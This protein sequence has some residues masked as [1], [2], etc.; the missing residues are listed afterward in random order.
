MKILRTFFSERFEYL[1]ILMKSSFFLLLCLLSISING[2]N[3]LWQPS[4]IQNRAVQ[5][6][7]NPLEKG[8]RLL[9]TQ[10][11]LPHQP[12]R[13]FSACNCGRCLS[14]L[15]ASP[16]HT[17]RQNTSI[18]CLFGFNDEK[19]IYISFFVHL[20]MSTTRTTQ[21]YCKYFHF[22]WLYSNTR[23][24]NMSEKWRYFNENGEFFQWNWFGW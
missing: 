10:S 4:P 1:T 23:Y 7:N 9:D 16:N 8:D 17:H 14:H 24:D 12:W 21:T 22:K 19:N 3:H 6:Y 18:T 13:R 20:N 15:I 5:K 11:S 2:P